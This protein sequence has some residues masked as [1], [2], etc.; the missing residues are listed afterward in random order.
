MDIKV[1]FPRLTKYQQN[2]INIQLNT[3]GHYFR[4]SI[5]IM[6]LDIRVFISEIKCRFIVNK[7]TLSGFCSLFS[8]ITTS[9]TKHFYKI[10]HFYDID[11]IDH[12]KDVLIYKLKL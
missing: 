4:I 8:E 12:N 1:V 7:T 3:L 11:L 6:F 9:S 2:R 10:I 5:F